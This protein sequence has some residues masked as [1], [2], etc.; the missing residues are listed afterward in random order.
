MPASFMRQAA[1]GPKLYRSRSHGECRASTPVA[2]W[3]AAWKCFDRMNARPLSIQ[4][5]RHRTNGFARRG[6][7]G[8]AAALPLPFGIAARM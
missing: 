1:K 6:C 3:A 4:P 7:A 8:D 2:S 5:G